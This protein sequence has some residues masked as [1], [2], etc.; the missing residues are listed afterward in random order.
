MI[1]AYTVHN[2][3][4]SPIQGPDYIQTWSRDFYCRLAIKA[5]SHRGQGQTYKRHGH[6]G[7]HHTKCDRHA[8]VCIHGRNTTSIHTG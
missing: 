2:T 5:Q 4:N 8:G 1:A 7:G 6:M 3:K